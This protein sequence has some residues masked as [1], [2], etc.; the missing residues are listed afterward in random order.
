MNEVE[1][2]IDWIARELR[3]E[4]RTGSSDLQLVNEIIKFADTISIFDITDDNRA[5]EYIVRYFIQALKREMRQPETINRT[6]NYSQA[7]VGY[8][9]KDGEVTISD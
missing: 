1:K 4:V 2:K 5:C 7:N 9:D 3:S 6:H 8:L